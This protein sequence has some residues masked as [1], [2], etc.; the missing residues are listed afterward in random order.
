MSFKTDDVQIIKLD[1]GVLWIKHVFDRLYVVNGYYVYFAIDIDDVADN[2]LAD[3]IYRFDGFFM[4]G[5]DVNNGDVCLVF[6]DRVDEKGIQY[7][8]RDRRDLSLFDVDV[9]RKARSVL[10]EYR[11]WVSNRN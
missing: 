8:S 11:N 3:L 10:N 5:F 7:Y 9:L 6:K 4:K 2:A 1:D